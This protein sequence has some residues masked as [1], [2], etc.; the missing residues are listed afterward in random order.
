MHYL[1]LKNTKS[2]KC[3][4]NGT[5]EVIPIW[6]EKSRKYGRVIQEQAL[7]RRKCLLITGLNNAGK[8]HWMTRL[9]DNALDIWGGQPRI[10]GRLFL[11]G[12]S[13]IGA[14]HEQ[15]NLIDW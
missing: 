13:A 15:D 8:S 6:V 5:R 7:S 3:R 2:E 10:T 4:K 12:L 9:Y 11:S 1:R 14:W